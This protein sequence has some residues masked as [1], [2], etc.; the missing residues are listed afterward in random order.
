MGRFQG[1][2]SPLCMYRCMG[3][4]PDYVGIQQCVCVSVS[5]SDSVLLVS[6]CKIVLEAMKNC[7]G[8]WPQYPSLICSLWRFDLYLQGV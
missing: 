7:K 4:N 1:G 8:H 5:V 3:R 2:K 6:C